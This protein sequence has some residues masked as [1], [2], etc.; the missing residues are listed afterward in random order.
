MQRDILLAAE[1]G[2]D[3]TMIEDE[4]PAFQVS[5]DGTV[6]ADTLL[7]PLIFLSLFLQIGPH[8]RMYE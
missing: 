8:V 4:A 5:S 1:C 2:M 6:I 3:E 7:F